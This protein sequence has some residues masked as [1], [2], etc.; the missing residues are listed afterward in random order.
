MGRQPCFSI[1]TQCFP[2]MVGVQPLLISNVLAAF[3]LRTRGRRPLVPMDDP[4]VM[5]CCFIYDPTP[6]THAM[7]RHSRQIHCASPDPHRCHTMAW[8]RH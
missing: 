7:R 5:L 4:P 1:L 8:L 2:P 3:W 6:V